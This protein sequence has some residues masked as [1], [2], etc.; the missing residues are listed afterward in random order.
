MARARVECGYSQSELA[1]MLRV[2]GQQRVVNWEQ[3]R[4]TPRPEYVAK[5][6]KLLS[7]SPFELLGADRGSADLPTLR[8]A[9]G[10]AAYEV[11]ARL[12][13]SRPTYS[14]LERGTPTEVTD[15]QLDLLAELF[16]VEPARVRSMVARA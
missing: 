5:L 8:I 7:V 16:E 10:M 12:G 1:R 4:E 3:G 14:R 9:H 15:A 11:A 6:A 13:V 2:A